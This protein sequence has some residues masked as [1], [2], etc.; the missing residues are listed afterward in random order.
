[1]FKNTS[2]ERKPFFPQYSILFNKFS[3]DL[4]FHQLH[5]YKLS[6]L[7]LFCFVN[8]SVV[9]FN[10]VT[11]GNS[12]NVTAA[13]H[14]FLLGI[15]INGTID[16]EA[17]TAPSSLPVYSVLPSNKVSSL[18]LSLSH[19]CTSYFCLPAFFVASL[20]SPG[21]P[22]QCCPWLFS[23]VSLNSCV[24]ALFLF[25]VCLFLLHCDRFSSSVLAFPSWLL[26]SSSR[27]WKSV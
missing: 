19:F 15:I 21:S 24:A 4:N 14:E 27:S 22:W 5:F 16:A 18:S 13:W 3:K 20:F 1:M 25:C 10:V 8:D 11:D 2:K 6:L 23:P 26:V 7:H 17:M 9:F 12:H